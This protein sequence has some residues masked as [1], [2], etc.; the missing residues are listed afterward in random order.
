MFAGVLVTV[1][2]LY[3]GA[4]K[5]HTISEALLEG[6]VCKNVQGSVLRVGI[7]RI[8]NCSQLKFH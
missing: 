5:K 6:S 2:V 4:L 7:L 8:G 3:A 1:P